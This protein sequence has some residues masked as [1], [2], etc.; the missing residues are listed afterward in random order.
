MLIRNI[1]IFVNIL[2]II[3]FAGCVSESKQAEEIIPIDIYAGLDNPREMKLSEIADDVELIKLESTNES[4]LQFFEDIHISEEY[5]ITKDSYSGKGKVLIF[6]RQGEFLHSIG[7]IGKGP[8]EYISCTKYAV[9]LDKAQIV[10]ADEVSKKLIAYSFDGKFIRE[11]SLGN[12][13]YSYS[14]MDIKFLDNN[15]LVLLMGHD[16]VIENP[17]YSI[18]VYDAELKIK[19]KLFRRTETESKNIYFH[20][21]QIN[22]VNNN[23]F[24]YEQLYDTIYRISPDLSVRPEYYFSIFKK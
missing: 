22:F 17:F 5:I 20:R 21:S 4:Y 9:N 8:G 15:N 3:I 6:N 10:I 24:F 2:I 7:N 23:I 16:P 13:G 14:F 18:R 1:P 12:F 19:D 11:S